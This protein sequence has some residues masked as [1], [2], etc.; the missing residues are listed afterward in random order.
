MGGTE[1][2]ESRQC[3]RRAEGWGWADKESSLSGVKDIDRELKRW[4]Q[5]LCR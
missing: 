2:V 3:I 5:W 4:S 1:G